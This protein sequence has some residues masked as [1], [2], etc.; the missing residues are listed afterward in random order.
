MAPESERAKDFQPSKH[1]KSCPEFQQQANAENDGA[2][3]DTAFPC[4]CEPTLTCSEVVE[5]LAECAWMSGDRLNIIWDRAQA[6][7]ILHSWRERR[8]QELE[9]CLREMV[10]QNGVHSGECFSC[11]LFVRE[12]GRHSAD[13]PIPKA[14]ALLANSEQDQEGREA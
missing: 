9:E 8:V 12:R 13:C 14:E 6:T 7:A 4:N 11:D 1:A 2:V 10:K 3:I 5:R